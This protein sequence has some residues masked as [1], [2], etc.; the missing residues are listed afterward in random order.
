MMYKSSI[1]ILTFLGAFLFLGA[2]VSDGKKHA[3]V[4][5]GIQATLEETMDTFLDANLKDDAP[6]LIVSVWQ[7]DVNLYTGMKGLARPNEPISENTLF[8]LGSIS[9][10]F[11]A[12]AVLKLYEYS[13]IDLQD[14]VLDYLPEL[15]ETWRK[16]TIHHLL[17]H[18]SGIPDFYNDLDSFKI[19]KGSVTNEK[20]LKYFIDN[21]ELKFE[22]GSSESY[23]NTGYVLLAE[24]V[25]RVSG[26]EFFEFIES[27][28]FA[29][30][31]MYN[32]FILDKPSRISDQM[33]LNKANTN[34][35]F[36]REFYSYG[37]ASQVSSIND[38]QSFFYAFM[39]GQVIQDDTQRLM[40]TSYSTASN[41]IANGTGYGVFF[42]S[43]D[44]SSVYG[45]SGSHDG[46]RTIYAVDKSKNAFVIVLGNGGDE[47]PDFSYMI[48]LTSEF[49]D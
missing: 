11:T 41:S 49:L 14:S 24:L 5:T 4:E 45:H 1:R 25:E 10:T 3:T 15:D 28:L 13:S 42:L 48:G 43:E 40:L 31:K 30:H 21:P 26:Q 7:N 12:I 8:R 39:S 9:K 27:E 36:G 17:T 34:L 38:M 32:T 37:V 47:M 46:F 18:Q 19:I 6:G 29:P 23:S 35:L 2:C 16:I 20:V 33:A 44:G 22:T